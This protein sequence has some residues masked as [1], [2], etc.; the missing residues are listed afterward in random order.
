MDMS[1]SYQS[2]AKQYLPGVDIVFDRFHVIAL[3]NKALD[4]V[5]RQECS[6]LSFGF[7][8]LIDSDILD[9]IVCFFMKGIVKWLFPT[10][11]VHKI[12]KR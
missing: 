10:K 4:K 8:S 3:I 12:A 2:A 9:E 11:K 7:I 6:N 1:K 5:R